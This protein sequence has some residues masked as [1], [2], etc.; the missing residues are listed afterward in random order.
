M[1]STRCPLTGTMRVEK[2]DTLFE[3]IAA[4]HRLDALLQLVPV[5]ILIAEAPSGHVVFENDRAREIL[6]KVVPPGSDPEE[7]TYHDLVHVPLTRA[8]REDK[9]IKDEVRRFPRRNGSWL[10]LRLH[11]TPL[12][13]DEGTVIAAMV[14]FEEVAERQHVATAL[15]EKKEALETRAET[16]SEA[17]KEKNEEIRRLVGALTLAEQRERR[18]IARLLHDD[19]QQLLFGIEMAVTQLRKHLESNEQRTLLDQIDNITEKALDAT[20]TLSIELY[21]AGLQKDGLEDA[22][23]WLVSHVEDLHNLS[24]ELNVQGKCEVSSRELREF[25]FQC[26]RELLFNVAKHANVDRARVEARQSERYLTLHVVDEGGGFDPKE[27]EQQ[28]ESRLGLASMRKR[29]GLLGAWLEIEA[30]PGEGTRVTITV[31]QPPSPGSE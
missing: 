2:Q 21:P 15:Q 3:Q 12:R 17:L 5:G 10:T 18:R 1:V 8:L 7:H 29:L 6:R 27:L 28:K 13:D 26:L 25:L 16:Q 20:R 11:T 22:L 4:T 19:L 23:R 31:P 30:A 9:A 24:V 14:A